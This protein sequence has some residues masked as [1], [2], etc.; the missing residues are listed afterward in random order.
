MGSR[1]KQ[2]LNPMKQVVF[3]RGHMSWIFM[4]QVLVLF[5][6]ESLSLGLYSI[7]M[8]SKHCFENIEV[9]HVMV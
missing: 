8:V 9:F 2:G 1:D 6:F 4:H 3:T 5:T 7:F